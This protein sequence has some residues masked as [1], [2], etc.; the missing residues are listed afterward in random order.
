MNVRKLEVGKLSFGHVE[1][2]IE[3]HVTDAPSNISEDVYLLIKNL[4]TGE[5]ADFDAVIKNSGNVD[6]EHIITRLLE[7][8]DVFEVKPGRLK[9]L[10]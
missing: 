3:N 4:D 5:G 7:S 8:G 2:K 6:A 10:E 9:V 1:T